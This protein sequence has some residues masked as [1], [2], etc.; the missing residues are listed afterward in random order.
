MNTDID[1]FLNIV[2]L[3]TQ[4]LSIKLATI[5][6]DALISLV[7][8]VLGAIAARFI[9]RFIERFL[10]DLDYRKFAKLLNFKPEFFNKQTRNAATRLISTFVF[11][12]VIIL[13]IYLISIYLQNEQLINS[14]LYL[15]K[16]FINVIASGG[17]LFLGA[18]LINLVTDLVVANVSFLSEKETKVFEF[19]LEFI[20]YIFTISIA[21]Y[22]LNIARP[23]VM[24]MFGGMTLLGL[25][26]Y[27]RK[28]K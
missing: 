10:Q 16:L 23:I 17:L 18:I 27:W 26:I 6:L 3:A 25:M 8:L 15:L 1:F 19:A 5:V 20:L 12:N 22:Q 14:A 28:S 7:L 24:I 2:E 11:W 4:G 9:S 21:M 13:V